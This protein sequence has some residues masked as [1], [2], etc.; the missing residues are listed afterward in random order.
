VKSLDL[1]PSL[2]ELPSAAS[3]PA[4]WKDAARAL[5]EM[6]R[7]QLG[8]E[9]AVG[10]EGALLTLF[11]WRNVP[12]DLQDAFS[13]AFSQS[14]MSLRD[15][16]EEVVE[17]GPEA[18]TGFLSCLKGKLFEHRLTEVLQER[19]PGY[20]FTIGENPTQPV[21]D[22]VG[23]SADG[24]EMLVQAKIGGATYAGEV[25]DRMDQS[26]DVVF[27]VGREIYDTILKAR[28]DLADQ[29]VNSGIPSLAFTQETASDLSTLSENLGIDV[30]DSL[31][32]ILPYVGEI[33][34]AVKFIIDV[35][36]T[37]QHL[38]EIRIEDRMRAHVMRALVL[39]SRFGLSA[40]CT[41]LGTLA[42][43]GAPPFGPIA[44]ALAGF[45]A[46]VYLNSKLK[47]RILELAL[48]ITGLS[49]DDLF[50]LRNKG[51]LDKLGA[52]FAASWQRLQVEPA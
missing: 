49:M 26:P 45:G 36:Q 10:G 52:S 12:D 42:G 30:P 5:V 6:D 22:L 43:S 37:E 46:S 20:T 23:R 29:L 39:I 31:G 44:G 27:G 9:C 34:L 19:F 51:A 7:D 4:N 35:I 41:T 15:H 25:I 50:Y 24:A 14:G 32:E 13:D 17:R 2:L 47:G 18:V 38:K 48:W 16:Y 40:V 11:H 28:P 8:I 1:L 33:V 3:P 21:W